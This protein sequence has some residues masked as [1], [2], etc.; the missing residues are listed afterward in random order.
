[1]WSFNP[2]HLLYK[3]LSCVLQIDYFSL[4]FVANISK[5]VCRLSYEVNCAFSI[6]FL[7][8][9]RHCKNYWRWAIH[10]GNAPTIPFV[11]GETILADVLLIWP[12]EIL[13]REAAHL[14]IEHGI[15]NVKELSL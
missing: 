14:S 2:Q 13:L 1:M 10:V 9:D 4:S 6:L 12:N 11:Y 15:T 3:T 5:I 7:H 8:Q